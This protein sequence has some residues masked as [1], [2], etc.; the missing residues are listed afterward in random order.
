ML[1]SREISWADTTLRFAANFAKFRL[2]KPKLSDRDF[3]SIRFTALTFFSNTYFRSAIYP[4]SDVVT[5][6]FRININLAY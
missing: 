5:C 6:H 3:T 1:T 4:A 2:E